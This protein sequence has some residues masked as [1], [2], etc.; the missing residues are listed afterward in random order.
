MRVFAAGT[1]LHEPGNVTPAKSTAALQYFQL[2]AWKARGRVSSSWRRVPFMYWNS[3][4]RQRSSPWVRLSG[5]GRDRARGKVSLQGSTS[6][7][8]TQQG[9]QHLIRSS[10][11]PA[12][13]PQ[14]RFASFG[15]LSPPR[16]APGEPHGC[17]ECS[18]AGTERHG[19][20][21]S[22][23][24][25]LVQGPGQARPPGAACT[26]PVLASGDPQGDSSREQGFK[27][28]LGY[29]RGSK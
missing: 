25:C 12:G 6:L 10:R 14:Q 29:K 3:T 22:S 18:G 16:E 28:R 24:G 2:P 4:G 11:S 13:Q 1:G 8:S 19:M 20:A 7:L 17:S 21:G 5:R 26:G 23:A 15:R 9:T 27:S